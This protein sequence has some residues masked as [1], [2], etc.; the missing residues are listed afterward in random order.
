MIYQM[1]V[2]SR[3][4]GALPMNRLQT[5]DLNYARRFL[6]V[7][8]ARHQL[9][10]IN[11]TQSMNQLVSP[12]RDI[13][14]PIHNWHVFKHA[15][16][17]DLVDK[18]ISILEL[19]E[20]AWVLDPFCGGG[21]TLLTCRENRLNSQGY[22][23]LPF[24]V[25]LTNA[26]LRNYDPKI[27]KKLRNSFLKANLDERVKV[28]REIK[29]IIIIPK[30]YTESVLAELWKIR[31]WVI[32]VKGEGPRA[33]FMLAFLN[34]AVAVSRVSKSGAFL[35]VVKKS[36]SSRSVRKVFLDN[37]DRMLIDLQGAQSAKKASTV[38]ASARVG[39]ARAFSDSRKYDAVITS[40]PYPN[41]HDYTRTYQL[42]LVLGF[43]QNNQKLKKI[44]YRTLRSH[45]EA[46]KRFTAN[47]YKKPTDLVK[48]LE[49]LERKELNNPNVLEMLEGYFE[50]MFL[51]LKK[52]RGRLKRGGRLAIVVSNVRFAGVN[53]PV[54]TLL[55]DIALSVGFYEKAIWVLRY[56]GN[57]SQ[58]MRDFNRKTSRESLLLLEK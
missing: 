19:K 4:Q 47:G 21:T 43:A 45:V 25:F 28:P 7:L 10:P 39:D 11:K 56:R 46:R 12:R 40:P 38:S 41:R 9:K 18:I 29:E 31:D 26:K 35:R 36:V 58:Q 13:N 1:E 48:V 30:A 50:D 34:T 20:G 53:V 3:V 14:R 24:S 57:S 6:G 22:D 27:L 44:R 37:V 49:R 8:M 16:P 32:R 51:V 2:Q 54:D 5:T 42:E 15:Y 52:L 33:F 23:I 17:K 55:L